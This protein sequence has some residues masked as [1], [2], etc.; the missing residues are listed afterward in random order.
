MKVDGFRNYDSFE[1]EMSPSLTILVGRNG[2]GKTNLVEA[3]QL[4]TETDSFRSPLWSDTINENTEKASLR[5]RAEGDSRHLEVDLQLSRRGPRK[6]TVNGKKRSSV[7]GVAGIIPAVVFTPDDLRIVKASS[8][9]RRGALDSLGNQLSPSYARLRLDY[10]RVLRQRNSLIKDRPTGSDVM[11]SLTEQLIES[12]SALIEHRKRLFERLKTKMVE[13]HS[14]LSGGTVLDVTYLESWE[15]DG[16]NLGQGET[17]EQFREALGK[18]KKL[19]VN[20]G[21]TR[22]GPHRDEVVFQ[23]DGREARAFASQGQQRSIALAWKLAEVRVIEDIA[24]QPPVLL[25]DDVMS[26]LDEERRRALTERIGS[27]IQTVITTT[28]IGYFEDSLISRAKVI[29]LL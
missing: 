11:G 19:E 1:L 23:V 22:V 24:V 4:L 28:N 3:I 25:L 10:E 20:R 12:G 14:A 7:I 8:D 18:T 5:L 2:V 9:R 15:R 6:Y 27:D 29:D 13:I 21:S 17:R 26:E 16:L